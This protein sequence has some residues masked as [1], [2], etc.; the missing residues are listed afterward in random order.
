MRIARPLASLLFAALTVLNAAPAQAGVGLVPLQVHE[1]T[2]GTRMPAMLFHPTAQQTGVT[3]V[4]PYRVQAAFAAP[5]PQQRHPLVLLSHGHGGS[6]LGHHPLAT[7]LADAGYVVA[8]IEH[9][10]DSH[11]DQSGFGTER[12]LLG[13][14]WHVSSLLDTLLQDPQLAA[15]IDPQRV[16]VAGFSAGGHT[17]LMLLGAVPDLRNRERY[18][19]LQP[20]DPELC[21]QPA[22]NAPALSQRRALADPRIRAAFVMAPLGVFFDPPALQAVTRP[23]FVH[24][25]MADT[26]LLPRWNA[27]A[28]RDGVAALSGWRGVVGADHFVYLAPCPA[29]MAHA[30]PTLC[31]DAAGI[32]RHQVQAQVAADAVA[33]FN[34]TLAAQPAGAPPH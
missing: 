14:A 11:A 2:T 25:A 29:P 1:P 32:D 10:G 5:R 16:G 30:L 7:A 26:V 24:A 17:S 21:L 3:Q 23:V 4:G 31:R 8:A 34:R 6:A 22:A 12:V 33:F 19:Q 18:C 9:A 20:Q 28:V 15:L 13:R 27:L